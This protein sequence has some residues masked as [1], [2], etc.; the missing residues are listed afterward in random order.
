MYSILSL[1]G[2]S[3]IKPSNIF[4]SEDNEYGKMASLIQ[5][6]DDYCT[7]KK[8]NKTNKHTTNTQTSSPRFYAEFF[9]KIIIIV[10]IT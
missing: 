8:Q 4:V 2:E 1:A 7:P 10:W 9:S 3:V 6:F 5:K